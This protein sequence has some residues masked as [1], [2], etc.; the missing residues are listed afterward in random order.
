MIENNIKQVVLWGHKLH[1]HTHSYIHAAYVKAFTYLGYK[2]LWLDNSDNIS[3]IDFA[4]S[5]FITEGQVD[6]KI[7]K[8]QDCYYILHNTDGKKYDSI[9][10]ENKFV[11]QVYTDDVIKCH[12]GIPIRADLLYYYSGD[13]LFMP[14]GTDLLPYEIDENIKKVSNNEINTKNQVIFVGSTIEPW[15]KV[16]DFCNRNGIQ[17]K[18]YT[19]VS[20]DENIKLIQESLLAPAVQST[21]QV[22][23]SYIPCRIFKNISYGKMGMTNNATVLRMFCGKII[24][25]RDIDTLM[26]KGLDFENSDP[27][28]KKESIID[29]MEFVRDNHTYLHRIKTMFWFFNNIINKPNLT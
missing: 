14:W 8:R 17:Y 21:W 22:D 24:H 1:S 16:R 5:L 23:N 10:N 29:L 7:P 19:S 26:Q 2:T 15:D 12:K 27:L 4:G 6:D 3:N 28:E 18:E 13:C 20:F 11:L 9:P 25:S